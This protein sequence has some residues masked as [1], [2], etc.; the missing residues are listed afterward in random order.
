MAA[1]SALFCIQHDKKATTKF[2]QV[3]VTYRVH[4]TGQ[5]MVCCTI[6]TISKTLV[7]LSTL[8]QKKLFTHIAR[9]MVD[10]SKGDVAPPSNFVL[11]NI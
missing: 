1:Q 2:N 8:F 4:E 3:L 9:L 5:Q 6:L 11:Y 10:I 7:L